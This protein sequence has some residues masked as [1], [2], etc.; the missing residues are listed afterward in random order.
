MER[1]EENFKPKSTEQFKEFSVPVEMDGLSC[2]FTGKISEIDRDIQL[3]LLMPPT[4]ASHMQEIGY[5]IA[6]RPQGNEA[7]LYIDK[8]RSHTDSLPEDSEYKKVH[9]GRFLMNNLLAFADTKGWKV[10]AFAQTDGRLSD[11]DMYDW[12]ERKGFPS[13]SKPGDMIREPQI[14]DLTQPITAILR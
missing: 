12:L 1:S 9:V 13:P 6:S 14:P 7:D 3:S 10:M 11:Q 8:I 5:V 2:I 4:A